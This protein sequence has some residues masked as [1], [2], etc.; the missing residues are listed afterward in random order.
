MPVLAK[1]SALIRGVKYSGMG[2]PPPHLM[3]MGIKGPPFLGSY[4]DGP[5]GSPPFQGGPP[6]PNMDQDS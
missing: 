4:D 3:E 1:T 6:D 5:N 2:G